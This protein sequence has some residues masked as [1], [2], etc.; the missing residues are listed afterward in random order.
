MN[1]DIQLQAEKLN[2]KHRQKSLWYRLLVAPI[3]I[4][5]FITTYA[6]IL[7]AITLES[8]PDTYCGQDEHIHDDTCY[9]VPGSPE[10]KEINCPVQEAQHIHT[11]ACYDA[12]GGLLCDRTETRILHTHNSFCFN[13]KGELIC[14]LAETEAHEHTEECYDEAGQLSCSQ[15]EELVHQHTDECLVTVLAV[16][17]QGLLCEKTE[18]KHTE[19]CFVKTEESAEESG[20]AGI[21]RAP[22]RTADLTGV[23]ME[24]QDS[25]IRNGCYQAVVT[26]MTEAQLEENSAYIKWYK[27][28]NGTGD[29]TEVTH[30]NFS[31]GGDTVINLPDGFSLN[32]ALDGGGIDGNKMTVTYR[33]VLCIGGEE[34]EITA[35]I[36][37]TTHQNQVLNGSFEAPDLTNHQ[38][39][40]FVPE[41]TAGLYWRTTGENTETEQHVYDSSETT[42]TGAHYIEIVDTTG[43]ESDTS[44]HKYLA[45]NWH[46]QG[47]ASDGKQ[48]AEIN[49]GAA[50]AL[51]QTIMT[52]PGTTMNWQIDHCGREGTD[53]MAVVIMAEELAQSI[54]T[55][56]Q[57]TT[58]IA[59]IGQY[60]GAV[61]ITDLTAS[62]GV[63]VT[64][65]GTYT[66]PAGQ[67]KTRFFFVAV[68][69]ASNN[70][71]V[72]NHID[73]AWFSQAMPPAKD[74]TP[75]VII[76][77]TVSANLT[78]EER[79]ALLYSLQFNISK[80]NS[81]NGSSTVL[82]T[83]TA[84][85][86]GA[87]TQNADGTYTLERAIYIGDSITESDYRNYRIDVTEDETTAELPGYI[88]TASAEK[89]SD[90]DRLLT[91][92]GKYTFSFTNVYAK[93]PKTL[94]LKKIVQ[95][96]DTTG[97][98]E[99]TV[100]WTAPDGTADSIDFSLRHNETKEL[101]IPDGAQVTIT[102]R[103][104]NGFTVSMKD[105]GADHIAADGDHYSFTLNGDRQIDVCNTAGSILP[106][107]GGVGIYLFTYGGLGL[108]LAVVVTGCLL[109]RR[110]GKEGE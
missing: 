20:A 40:E 74:N 45:K 96:S 44:S 87:W 34:T 23:T 70:D 7:P 77:K 18:H 82:K 81:R 94:T 78:E 75:Q 90:S 14:S 39:Q 21:H 79:D 54:T 17:P 86:L 12:D 101:T 51:Y 38:Y 36:T 46:N 47:S 102:E 26:G 65:S 91:A 19:A 110:Y 66:V 41:G 61:A 107:T 93:S 98:F 50:G 72:G 33:A 3:C 64:H 16:E 56:A 97:V 53:K 99:F 22:A 88:L 85:Q 27:Q 63:W 100:S 62:Q 76:R 109:R 92:T 55:Q 15:P 80:V 48:Y 68:E 89:P 105:S 4:V 25:I 42:Q 106:E 29:F 30:K 8:T 9:E 103:Q 57:L 2:K 73:N 6:L 52:V 13:D 37:N 24:I 1:K 28:I 31:I 104:H 49:A 69:T 83:L 60:S 10:R 11:E 5:V 67:H 59:N 71:Y 43:S 108:M 32:L 95:A 84:N 58:A 35:E